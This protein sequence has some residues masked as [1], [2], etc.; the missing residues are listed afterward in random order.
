[1]LMSRLTFPLML[2]LRLTFTFGAIA[3]AVRLTLARPPRG[4]PSAC[5]L[6]R[7]GSN[8]EDEGDQERKVGCVRFMSSLLLAVT[9]TA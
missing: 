5:G 2:T 3:V 9:G 7:L 8:D 1:M 6:R 4:P